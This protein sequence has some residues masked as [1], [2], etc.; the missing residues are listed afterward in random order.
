DN[1][2][3]VA[4]MTSGNIAVFDHEVRRYL[5]FVS[6]FQTEVVHSPNGRLGGVLARVEESLATKRPGDVDIPEVQDIKR[7]IREAEA[8][9]AVE[10]LGIPRDACRFLNLPFYQTG[11]VRKDPVGPADVRI[12]RELF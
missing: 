10:S 9:S 8:V 7:Q 3:I 11:K 6:R 2:L 1:E 5:D 12:I 4:Y